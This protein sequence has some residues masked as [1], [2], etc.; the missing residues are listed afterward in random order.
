MK[1]GC[2]ALIKPFPS[3]RR[4]FAIIRELGFDYA[5]LTD[6]HDGATLGTEYGFTA[7]ASLAADAFDSAARS[8]ASQGDLKEV[9]A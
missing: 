7:S 1:I 8:I 4:Q 2:F 3:L 6:N 5:D 9:T